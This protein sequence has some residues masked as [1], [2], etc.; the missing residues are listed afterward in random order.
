MQLKLNES[1]AVCSCGD[2][3]VSSAQK[4]RALKLSYFTVGYNL[5]EAIA[6]IAA[7]V[8]A[9]SPALIGFGLDSVVESLSGAVMIWRFTGHKEMTPEAEEK[10]EKKAIRLIGYTFFIF[11]AYVCYES[12]EKLI[13]KEPP[14]PSVFGIVI[15]F[16][17]IVVMPSLFLAKYRLGR[18]L[19]SRS[20]IADSKQTLT[21]M[22]L[23]VSLLIGLGLN[24]VFGLWWADPAAGLLIVG[25]LIKE[26]RQALR[27]EKLCTC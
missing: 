3:C 24:Y 20:L 14:E 18:K 16:V 15:A 11:A 1:E 25:F 9:G 26:G 5:L 4:D 23:S 6:S 12:L 8:M 22:L 17:S 2:T 10:T 13:N 19:K 27:E 21:C 7:G